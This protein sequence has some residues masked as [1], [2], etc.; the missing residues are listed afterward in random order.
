MPYE[1]YPSLTEKERYLYREAG[2]LLDKWSQNKNP[3]GLIRL[4]NRDDG[5]FHMFVIHIYEERARVKRTAEFHR[6]IIAWRKTFES[7]MIDYLAYYIG[8]EHIV[9]PGTRI[10]GE[11]IALDEIGQER[12]AELGKIH[13]HRYEGGYCIDCEAEDPDYDWEDDNHEHEYI[14]GDPYC[15]GCG[16]R[17]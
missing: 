12:L 14:E 3:F 1:E 17:R 2:Y 16:E 5:S 4:T 9:T 6:E 8:R 11:I 13:F 15:L 10:N 7:S